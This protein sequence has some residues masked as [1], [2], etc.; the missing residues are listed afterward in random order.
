ME[1]QKSFLAE[2]RRII[3]ESNTPADLVTQW[4]E[5]VNWCAEGYQWDISEY[6]NEISV[7]NELEKMLS[8]SKLQSYNELQQ[9]KFVVSEIDNRFKDL[10]KEDISL[11]NKT[12]WWEQGILK[13]AGEPYATYFHQA[14]GISIEIV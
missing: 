4:Q 12:N 5:F 2:A 6:N 3:G 10:L 7:R 14:Y 13:K 8:A 9:L 11:K 1:N